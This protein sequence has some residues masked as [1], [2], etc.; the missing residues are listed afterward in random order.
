MHFLSWGGGRGCCKT[1]SP[2]GVPVQAVKYRFS[3]VQVTES[4][5]KQTLAG[6][7]PPISGQRHLLW[8]PGHP[9]V[10]G[11]HPIYLFIHSFNKH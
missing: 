3:G 5:N 4:F 6:L 11:N 7:F 2:Q 10:F 9:L 8:P 1:C